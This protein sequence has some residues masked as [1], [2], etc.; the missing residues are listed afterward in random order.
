MSDQLANSQSSHGLQPLIRGT[1]RRM[2]IGGALVGASDEAVYETI[3][4]IDGASLGTVPSASPKDVDR[5]VRAAADAADSWRY[6]DLSE[7]HRCVCQIADAIDAD[8]QALADLDVLDGGNPISIARADVN[9]SA[10]RV[11]YLAGLLHSWG[12]RSI[13][14]VGRSLDF[15]IREPYGVTARL[16]PFNHPLFFAAS[17]IAAPLL[18]GNTVVLKLSDQTPLSG[19]R[20]AEMLVDIFPPGVVNILSGS[21]PVVGGRLVESELVQRIAFIGSA[22]TG[23]SIMRAAASRVAPVTMELGGKNPMIVCADANLEKAIN[24]SIRGMNFGTAGQSCGSY[25]RLFVHRAI[26]DD[27]L[28]GM[29]ERVAAIKVGNPLDEATQM[30]PLVDARAHA[31]VLASV[32]GA[33][34]EGAVAFLPSGSGTGD[35]PAGYYWH[36]TILSG[37]SQT[38]AIASQE[39]FG[40]VLAVLPWS[41][42][43][44]VVAAANATPYGLTANI[45]SQNLDLAFWLSE[46]V[47]AGSVAINGD[48]RQH[49]VGA[50]FGGFGLSGIGKEDSIDELLEATREKNVNVFLANP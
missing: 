5:A 45:H 26:Y 24:A 29:A 37:V 40:P 4:P 41:E 38:M 39:V 44:E 8:A 3:S 9:G 32:E 42:P 47:R 36:P 30:G 33:V 2:L 12:G 7:R 31:K 50:P 15:T 22:A 10:A 49:W 25:S 21:G 48:G 6:T 46:R 20:L 35:L 19:L 16:V 34:D 28:H 23:I 1:N 17:K 11:R 43:T 18:T 27:V 13:P 14:V